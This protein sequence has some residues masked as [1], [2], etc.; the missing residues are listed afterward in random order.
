MN[1]RK[2]GDGWESLVIDFLK[3]QNINVIERNFYTKHGE[4]DLIF[5]DNGYLV[6]AEVKE[7]YSRIY[8]N[9]LEAITYRKMQSISYSSRVY[10]YTHGL[11][12]NI[13]VR[14]DV[15]GILNGEITWIK[16]A[17]SI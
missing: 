13:P 10:L 1:K 9:P 8:G 15:F 7:R 4:I 11:K 16:N 2:I 14:F 6:F 5:K 17:F 3:K 12:E